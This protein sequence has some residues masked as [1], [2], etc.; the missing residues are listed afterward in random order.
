MKEEREILKK[1]RADVELSEKVVKDAE[2]LVGRYEEG[3][4]SILGFLVGMMRL[5]TRYIPK[6]NVLRL[7]KGVTTNNESREVGDIKKRQLIMVLKESLKLYTCLIKDF[8][9]FV[10]KL[11]KLQD[12][13]ESGQITEIDEVLFIQ[14]CREWVEE[15]RYKVE[16]VFHELSIK[17]NQGGY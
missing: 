15:Y 3:K 17:I 6:V 14:G 9:T 5:L 16:G 4:T 8:D 12:K 7:Y 10:S 11:E 2:N 1:L 13:S